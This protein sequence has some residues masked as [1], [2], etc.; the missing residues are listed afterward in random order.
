MP[1][2]SGSNIEAAEIIAVAAKGGFSFVVAEGGSVLTTGVKA[3]IR[4]PLGPTDYTITLVALNAAPSGSVVLDFWYEADP[5]TNGVPTV[6]DTIT[7]SDKPGLTSDDYI[8]KSSFTGWTLTLTAGG[9]LLINIDSVSI[10]TE[11]MIAI[12]LT[13]NEP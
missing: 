3:R 6:A 2:Q 12:D 4:L 8:E 9:L 5:E 11:L 7:A 13:R 10:M 1:I